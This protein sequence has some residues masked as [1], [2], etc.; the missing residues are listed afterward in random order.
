MNMD[1]KG[2]AEDLVLL[3]HLKKRFV[4]IGCSDEQA[5]QLATHLYVNREPIVIRTTEISDNNNNR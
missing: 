3:E 2:L 5:F 4:D 1:W